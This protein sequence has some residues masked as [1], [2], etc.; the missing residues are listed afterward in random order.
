M[1]KGI[2][3]PQNIILNAPTES[4]DDAIERVGKVLVEAG[5]VKKEYIRG[6][7]IREDALSTVLENGVALP[8]GEKDYK[9]MIHKTGLAAVTYPQGIEWNGETV[10]L[11][12]GI[13]AGIDDHLEV[14]RTLTRN[15]ETKEE[16]LS[17]IAKNDAQAICD[18]LLD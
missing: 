5:F 2:L 4:R 9:R 10:Y 15:L 18:I 7:L 6:M 12:F 1:R 3:E 16:V 17:L 14:L 13:A 8:H 11:V